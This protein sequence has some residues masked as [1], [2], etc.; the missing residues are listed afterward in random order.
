MAERELKQEKKDSLRPT[1]C[2]F[3][4]NTCVIDIDL[5]LFERATRS[6]FYC[7]TCN[8]M[9]ICNLPL[10]KLEVG[11]E[12]RYLCPID[13]TPLDENPFRAKEIEL[14]IEKAKER[15]EKQSSENNEEQKSTS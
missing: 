6:T 15:L 1:I 5:D 8:R 10:G 13:H 7:R 14:L 4:C 3:P 9:F 12:I 11:D 2:I